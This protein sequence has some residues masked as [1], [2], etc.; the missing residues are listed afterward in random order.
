MTEDRYNYLMYNEEA[1]LTI[2]EMNA[3]WH[4][5]PDWDFLLVNVK[6]SPERSGCSC[7]FKHDYD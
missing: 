1:L 6:T 4:F 5:C 7:E 2:E 3:G